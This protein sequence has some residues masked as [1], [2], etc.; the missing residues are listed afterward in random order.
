MSA[1]YEGGATKIMNAEE[2]I[3]EIIAFL[4]ARLPPPAGGGGYM[5]QE[6]Y[7]GDLFNLFS[8]AYHNGYINLGASPYLSADGLKEIIVARWQ[9][10]T[11]DQRYKQIDRLCT[12][13]QEWHYAWDKH[14]EADS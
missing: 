1:L 9:N 12:M 14:P 11:E 4:D 6:P 10:G 8:E 2:I 5:G 13:W 7:K 3:T